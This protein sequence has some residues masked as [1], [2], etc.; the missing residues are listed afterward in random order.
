MVSSPDTTLST[1]CRKT[2]A[3]LSSPFGLPSTIAR[4]SQA[5][6]RRFHPAGQQIL[7]ELS[8]RIILAGASL[9][10]RALEKI[11]QIM[12]VVDVETTQR[13]WLSLR[14]P[15]NGHSVSWCS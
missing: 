2:Q 13:R 10:G 15:R 6:H 4:Q 3:T 1:S 7:I 12:I 11:L 8:Q 5:R 9:R 14:V